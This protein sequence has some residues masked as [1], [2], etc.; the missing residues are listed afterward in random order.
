MK[1]LMMDCLWIGNNLFRMELIFDGLSGFLVG[2]ALF[3]ALM[4]L[5]LM[6]FKMLLALVLR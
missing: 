3:M 2:I 5:E 4:G 1:D 6:G